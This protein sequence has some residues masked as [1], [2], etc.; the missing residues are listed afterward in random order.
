MSWA[1]Q[2]PT[3]TVAS[4]PICRTRLRN[5]LGSVC[6]HF[7]TLGAQKG[8]GGSTR[9]SYAGYAGRAKHRL[10]QR[11]VDT[12]VARAVAKALDPECWLLALG[13]HSLG[14]LDAIL[15]TF[16]EGRTL[17]GRVRVKCLCTKSYFYTYPGMTSPRANAIRYLLRVPFLRRCVIPSK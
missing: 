10:A 4:S 6:P 15:E 2:G 8:V 14:A 7:T 12:R 3:A 9:S 5:R 11:K 13:E 17:L 1:A 16:L